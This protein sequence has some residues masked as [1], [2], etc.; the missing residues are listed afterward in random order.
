[1]S[2][3][4]GFQSV[5]RSRSEFLQTLRAF[6]VAARLFALVVAGCL[7][8][9]LLVVVV[10]ATTTKTTIRGLLLQPQLAI[11]AMSY[12][13][14]HQNGKVLPVKAAIHQTDSA[15]K[16]IRTSQL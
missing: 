7:A 3:S 8:D 9:H 16:L 15:K 11:F 13:V 4:S 6:F 12:G 2:V 1:M 10:V 5:R 14:S